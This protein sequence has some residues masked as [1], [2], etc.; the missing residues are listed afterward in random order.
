M[1]AAKKKNYARKKRG[2]RKSNKGTHSLRLTLSTLFLIVFV[3]SCLYGL[4][5]LKQTYPNKITSSY[6]P[7]PMEEPQVVESYQTAYEDVYALLQEELLTG[8][9]SQGWK[10]L[11]GDDVLRLK[12]H[13][14][15][16]Q[17]LRLMELVTRIALTDSPAHLDLAPRKGYVRLF[18]SGRL[19]VELQYDVSPE[20][21]RKKPLIAI[22]MDDMG[23]SL[24]EIERL[25]ALKVPVTP[26]ILPHSENARRSTSMLDQA[27]R[28]FLIHIPMQPKSYPAI[29]PGPNALLLDLGDAELQMRVKSYLQQ[30]PGA[31]GGNNHMG[32][33]FTQERD[34][35]R[36]VL[37][38]LRN[39]NLFFIDSR[40]IAGSVAFD[41]ARR[42]GM[43]T[44][45]RHIFLDNE[46]DVTYIRKQLRAMVKIAEEKGEAIA[47]C[48]PYRQT[49]DALLQ[50]QDWLRQQRVDF[51]VA[52]RLA[53]KR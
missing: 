30:V 13:G 49:F 17:Q 48:H 31:A 51:V 27:G 34:K 44:G 32:S 25:L 36:I 23:R 52:S 22:I 16:P 28:E 6:V 4:I 38:E 26:S 10:R 7:T 50:E 24:N 21:S 18:W 45:T 2:K 19:R 47:I 15:Y 12:M 37:K 40:T 43:R 42:L 3:G 53:L 29:S 41:E 9:E 46:E 33:M 1:A 39:N 20:I 14:N 11:P 8:P 35:M 5:H